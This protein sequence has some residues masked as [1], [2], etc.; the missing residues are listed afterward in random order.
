V[1]TYSI[2]AVHLEI[3]PGATHYHIARVKLLGVKGDFPRSQIIA[4]IGEGHEF[5]TY[6]TPPARVYVR[7]CPD[8][9]AGDYITTSPDATTR[10]NL[11]DL[12][13]Y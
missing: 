8:C 1:A 5:W 6:A 3:A 9:Y 4:W 11:L 12:P 13:N 2:A 10:N 7:G